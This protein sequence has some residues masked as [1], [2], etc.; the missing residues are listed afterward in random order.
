MEKIKKLS[1]AASTIAATPAD[2]RADDMRF[3]IVGIGA[4]AGGLEATSVLLRSLPTDSGMA[5][6]LVQHLDPN[7]VSA[8]TS[9][10]SKTTTMPVREVTDGMLVQPNEV[11]VIP[12]ATNLQLEGELLRLT[13][14]LVALVPPMPI[15][16][17]L[18]SLATERGSGAVGVIL[19][20]TGTDGTEGLK[21]IKSEGGTTFAQDSTATHTGMPDSAVK[22]GCVDF[23]LPPDQIA[24]RLKHS[25]SQSEFLPSEPASSETVT[26]DDKKVFDSVLSQLTKSSGIDFLGYKVPT[27]RRRIERRMVL[28]RVNSLKDYLDLL[29]TNSDELHSLQQEVL[30]HVT[31]FFRDPE[32]FKALKTA[33]LPK[34]IANRPADTP[35][36]IWI[37]GCSTGEEVYSIVICIIE[38]LE[39]QNANFPV[40]VFATDISELAIEKARAA[41]YPGTIDADVAAERL[42]KFF[43]PCDGGYRIDKRIRD[44][45]VFARQDVTQD[46]PFSQLDLISCRNVLIYL[47][48]ELQSRV[49]PVFHYALKPDG[50][51]ILGSAESTGCFSELFTPIDKSLRCYQRANIPSQLAFHFAAGKVYGLSSAAPANRVEAGMRGRDIL[52]E[53]DRVVLNRYA[54]PG[55]VVDEQFRVVQ[56]RGQTGQ[57]LEP[58]PGLPSY[59]LLQ[60]VRPGLLPVFARRSNWR[61]PVACHPAQRLC[62]S[63][64]YW[65]SCKSF[66][67][68][69]YP[70]NCG[71]SWSC[72]K[73]FSTQT[74]RHRRYRIKNLQQ[75]SQT[76][77][78]VNNW[79]G[80]NSIWLQRR[81]IF[82]RSFR[83][84]MLQ[85]KN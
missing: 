13:P 80:C 82:N 29:L 84:R 49:F 64:E 22:A 61:T 76:L 45:C 21:A 81:L 2:Q 53:A 37:P 69:P 55:V 65:F 48:P 78:K 20:G 11:Y 27:L 85:T 14:R 8:L 28:C 56:F 62:R 38:F 59:D 9:I 58:P 72:S 68:Q 51:L 46:P 7:H 15:D 24:A 12:P 52:D 36:R 1:A 5:F 33:V 40:K 31:R 47:G 43:K 25:D 26:D 35:F 83:A 57:F 75:S 70:N 32:V 30:I 77:S 17:F 39:E 23:I 79:P 74:Y 34:L 60:M 63:T 67:S 4:S 66:P 18:L 19:S 73:R 16:R 42:E 41:I 6:V 54:P 71:T 10:L 50:F 44:T 3:P